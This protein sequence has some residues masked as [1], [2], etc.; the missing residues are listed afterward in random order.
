VSAGAG[1]FAPTPFTEEVEA[2]GLS[3]PAGTGRREVPL[4]PRHSV[5]S[6]IDE[7]AA[8][9]SSS[10]PR[11]YS[12]PGR[13]GMTRSCGPRALRM[14]AGSRTCGPRSMGVPS[15][16]VFGSASSRAP[17]R[18]QRVLQECVR[19]AGTMVRRDRV[20]ASEAPSPNIGT[21][22]RVAGGAP[23]PNRPARSACA[24]VS[25]IALHLSRA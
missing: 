19:P 5:G 4:T 17:V 9:G 8:S 7:S 11:T 25:T 12:T 14:A 20:P 1:F 3:D 23:R 13:R 21:P 16:E 22:A 2:V 24:S 10:T 6:S 18:P 15:T